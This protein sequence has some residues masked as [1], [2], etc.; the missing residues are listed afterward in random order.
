MQKLC[1]IEIPGFKLKRDEVRKEKLKNPNPKPLNEENMLEKRNKS[2]ATQSILVGDIEKQRKF[3]RG[4]I[5]RDEK[6]KENG[7][8]SQ[9]EDVAMEGKYTTGK[10][11]FLELYFMRFWS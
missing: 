3:L 4:E 7:G 1:G 11:K 6:E 8:E 5:Q 10:E 9:H 2:R